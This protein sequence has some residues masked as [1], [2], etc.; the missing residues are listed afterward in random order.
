MQCPWHTE[1]AHE[2]RLVCVRPPVHDDCVHMCTHTLLHQLLLPHPLV[3]TKWHHL[4]LFTPRHHLI[5]CWDIALYN[6]VTSSHEKWD[7]ALVTSKICCS[8]ASLLASFLWCKPT[9]PER[10]MR[11]SSYPQ[12]IYC[13]CPQ[14][15]EC[16]PSSPATY[17]VVYKCSVRDI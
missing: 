12:G 10:L 16:H 11:T 7:L 15:M 1:W 13:S 4:Y 2:S 6:C 5:M 9:L 17:L 8:N 3:I 14:S